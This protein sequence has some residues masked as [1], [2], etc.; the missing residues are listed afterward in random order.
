MSDAGLKFFATME[1]AD[2]T[3]A[4]RETTN[5]TELLTWIMDR[6]DTGGELRQIGMEAR[7]VALPNM[8]AALA[9]GAA[10]ELQ[11]Y[12]AAHPEVGH[13]PEPDR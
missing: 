5:R 1:L 9:H 10:R 11:D 8:L 6:R 7:G 12:R 2:G 3:V 13:D 4:T